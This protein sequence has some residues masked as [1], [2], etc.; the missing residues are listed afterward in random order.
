M[1]YSSTFFLLKSKVIIIVI[2][3]SQLLTSDTVVNLVFDFHKSN[4][5]KQIKELI[6]FSYITST[7]SNC[8]KS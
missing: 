4:N 3:D 1:D 6:R 5:E 8:S 7:L 2:I